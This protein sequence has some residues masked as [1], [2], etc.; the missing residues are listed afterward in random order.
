MWF[1]ERAIKQRLLRSW[2]K[3]YLHLILM[4]LLGA[5]VFVASS[6]SS[7]IVI[8]RVD[9]VKSFSREDMMGE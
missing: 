1:I 9:V 6:S 5:K 2:L 4:K 7:G 8:R 3:S